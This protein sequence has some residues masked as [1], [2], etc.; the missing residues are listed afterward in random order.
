MKHREQGILERVLDWTDGRGDIIAV[1]MTGSRVRE[2][3]TVDA[4]SDH[5]IELYLTDP[6][7]LA[8]E[9]WL[10]EIA[11]VWVALP[12]TS[13]EGYPVHLVFFA[14]AEKVDFQVRPAGEF[15]ALASAGKIGD[16]FARADVWARGYQ[17]LRDRTG[18]ASPLPRRDKASTSSPPPSEAEYL[19]V[20]TEFW[21][22]AA[23][24]PRYLM[25]DELWM[26]KTRDGT[27][28]E[29]LLQMLE[30]NAVVRSNGSIDVWYDGAKL[31]SWVGK[32]RWEALGGTFGH[33]D[34]AD[35][36]RALLATVD[37]FRALSREVSN[38]CGFDYPQ[39]QDDRI[40]SYILGFQAEV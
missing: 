27:M 23:H 12:L 36:W 22:E 4:Y 24:V 21:F 13:D 11:P 8:D 30:W 20:N 29:L 35:S 9:G 28:K 18:L 15:I 5:D 7:L 34:R 16:S 26:V 3:G 17:I 2:D 25:R 40:S 38:R 14:D 1:V 37:L 6:T 32:D 19:A 10:E 33:F 31:T 39:E